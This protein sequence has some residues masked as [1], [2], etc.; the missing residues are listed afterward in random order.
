[1]GALFCKM[2]NFC[3]GYSWIGY[4]LLIICSYFLRNLIGTFS[5][6]TFNSVLYVNI[7]LLEVLTNRE[8]SV[9]KNNLLW[10][11]RGW[12]LIITVKANVCPCKHQTANELSCIPADGWPYCNLWHQQGWTVNTESRKLTWCLPTLPGHNS[13]KRGAPTRGSQNHTVNVSEKHEQRKY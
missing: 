6:L 13:L 11:C 5:S 1:M 2:N 10:A 7:Q 4:I 8:V 12:R 9:G 3:H